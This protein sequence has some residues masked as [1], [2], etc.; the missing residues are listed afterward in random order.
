MPDQFIF[1][2]NLQLG[3]QSPDGF[4][5][6]LLRGLTH[7]LNN[8]I[9]VIQGFGTL[10]QMNGELDESDQENM[11]HIKEAS[12]NI[13]TLSERIRAAGGCAN[14]R[15]QSLNLPD[16]LNAVSAS[17]HEPFLLADVPFEMQLAAKIP[18]VQVDP[19]KLKVILMELLENAA[20]SAQTTG[21]STT[22]QVTAPGAVSPLEE[23]R[24]D[25]VITNTGTEISAE[26]LPTVFQPFN[27]SKAGNHLG[28]GLTI[29]AMLAHQTDIK[30][31]IASEAGTTTCWIS[32]PVAEAGGRS[33]A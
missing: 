30:L 32:V 31:G 19:A 10:I 23:Q 7:K 4:H 14:V 20:E 28:L 29:A 11:Q 24:V 9:G 16:Y 21:G 13:Y 15:M 27:G 8:L 22:M 18:A 33:E 26:K 17:F 3:H 2:T 6:E 1:S 12:V 5:Q 25:I